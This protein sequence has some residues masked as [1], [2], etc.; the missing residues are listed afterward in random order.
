MS[1]PQQLAQAGLE[2]AVVTSD[3]TGISTTYF[4]HLVHEIEN[5]LQDIFSTSSKIKLKKDK[6]VIS[7]LTGLALG[8]KSKTA[9]RSVS[10]S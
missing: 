7:L 5:I 2:R 4:D 6:L 9:L 10:S 8:H 1:F 3:H